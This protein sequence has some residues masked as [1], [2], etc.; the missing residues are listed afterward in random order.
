MGLRVR[1]VSASSGKT[2]RSAWLTVLRPPMAV[3]LTSLPWLRRDSWC[4][5]SSGQGQGPGPGRGQV[6]SGGSW[7]DRAVAWGLGAVTTAPSS[8]EERRTNLHHRALGRLCTG[9]LGLQSLPGVRRVG[10]AAWES[11]SPQGSS[12]CHDLSP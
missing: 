11:R 3:F 1:L 6:H 9:C 4:K 5:L 7:R 8:G 12:R 10:E 2:S